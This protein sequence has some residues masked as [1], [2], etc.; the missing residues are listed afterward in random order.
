MKRI[1]TRFVSDFD[2]AF[3]FIAGVYYSIEENSAQVQSNFLNP[4][5][6]IFLLAP[7]EGRW[8]LNDRLGLDFGL[9]YTEDE[10]TLDRLNVARTDFNGGVIGSF[11]PGNTTGINN[12]FVPPN[13]FGPGSPAFF[14]DGPP[15]N[16]SAQGFTETER[17]VTGKIGLD[18][19]VSDDVLVYASYNRG[20]RSGSINNGLQFTALANPSDAYAAPEFV[21]AYE[22]GLKGDFLDGRLR[23][24]A[25]A[26]YY[27]YEDQQFINQVGLAADLENA[28][29]SEI[30][31]L[32]LEVLALLSDNLSLKLGLGLLDTE[33][34]EL[35]LSNALDYDIPTSWGSLNA[36]VD[37]NYQGDQFYSAY[38]D[39]PTFEEIGQ[40]AYWLVNSRLSAAVGDEGN[41]TISAWV[42]NLADEEYDVYAINLQALGFDYFLTGAPRTYGLEVGYRF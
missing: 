14:L 24:N 15:T 33:F 30:L 42:K 23:V 20:F 17:E 10:T 34:T 25:T 35:S 3:N 41:L 18:Y 8:E 5:F 21:D 32:E 7:D 26:F 2:G 27:E 1:P 39:F 6:N 11:I 22:L 19:K 9:R 13:A 29:E 36:H 31:G 4:F 38:N 12:P 40:D 28:G 16:E 37:A